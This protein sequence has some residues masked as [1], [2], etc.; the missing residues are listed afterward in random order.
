L[1]AACH[2]SSGPILDVPSRI[3]KIASFQV[4]SGWYRVRF[5]AAVSGHVL[6][7]RPVGAPQQQQIPVDFDR[8]MYGSRR[9]YENG[10]FA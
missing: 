10:M 2:S 6:S 1:I 5:R 4:L 8:E 7:Y 3:L 9:H